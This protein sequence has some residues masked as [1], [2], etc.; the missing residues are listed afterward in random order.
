MTGRITVAVLGGTGFIGAELVRLLSGHPMVELA[1]VSSEQRAGQRIGQVV[2]GLRHSLAARQPLR[3]LAELS[4]VDVAISCL[5]N[6]ILPQ[7]LEAVCERANLVLNVA[8]DFRLRDPAEVARHYPA[9]VGGWRE[10]VPYYVPEFSDRPTG[11]VLN[12]PGCMAAAALYALYPL[13]R[14]DLVKPDLVVDAKTGSSG[15]GAGRSEHPAVRDGNVRVHRLH[16]HRHAPELR[17]ALA[18]LTGVAADIQFSAF[19]LPVARGVL[20]A[21]Y[22]RLR[23][24]IGAADVRRAYAAAY[25]DTAFVRVSNGRAAASFPMLKTVAGSNLA[26]V[27]VAVEGDRCVSVAALD[28]L[29]KGG[30]GQ[31]V[32][33]LN[34]IHDLDE[35]LGLA[36]APRWP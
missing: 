31:A 15:G 5:P 26:E 29:V 19:S 27:G 25:A 16:G 28:N 17:Q 9:S 22:S 20:V 14:A 12:L 21:A 8:G 3:T 35:R 10:P 23:A 33:A 1:F 32:Q 24:G 13:L 34:R 6:G 30:A 2:P 18:D 11:P 36:E 7:H 4:K